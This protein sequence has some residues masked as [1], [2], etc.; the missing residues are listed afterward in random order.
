[1][2]N[3]SIA[4]LI[5]TFNR[6]EITLKALAKIFEI[7]ESVQGI[8][9][10][11]CDG[12]STDG[13]P[14]HIK[15]HFPQVKVDIVQKAYWNTATLNAWEVAAVDRFDYYLWMN[16]DLDLFV[17]ATTEFLSSLEKYPEKCAISV[18]QIVDPDTRRIVYSGLK[19]QSSFRKY[20]FKPVNDLET[21]PKTFNGNFVLIPECAASKIGLLDSKF[22]H[23]FGDIDYGLRAT[24]NGVEIQL[25]G[26]IGETCY[27]QV[28]AKSISRVSILRLHRVMKDKKIL[29]FRE[30]A[31]FYRKHEPLF[32]PLYIFWR[33]I[34][35]LRLK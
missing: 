34:R 9:V 7:K 8:E 28:F 26:I 12:G 15:N 33:Y 5:A 14:E 27:N 31:H 21:K 32:W 22:S 6:S 2:S 23:G 1:M 13:T 11:V 24:S 16:D 30:V 25:I 29:P 35:I 4:I 3:V 18:G 19:S 17:D 20:S 10:F